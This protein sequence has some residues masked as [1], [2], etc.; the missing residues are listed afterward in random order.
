MAVITESEGHVSNPAVPAQTITLTTET[1]ESAALSLEGVDH[2]E[3]GDS[4]ALGVLGIGDCVA[5][6]ALEEGL[7]NT[8]GLFVDHCEAGG[9][10]FMGVDRRGTSVPDAGLNWATY[11]QRYA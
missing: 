7:K 11:W 6:D 9:F 1:V 10:S 8:T 5:N 3:R 4:L 2:I